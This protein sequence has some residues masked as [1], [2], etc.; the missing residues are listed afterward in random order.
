MRCRARAR[1][2]HDHGGGG[3]HPAEKAGC[4]ANSSSPRSS[5]QEARYGTPDPERVAELAATLERIAAARATYHLERYGRSPEEAEQRQEIVPPGHAHARHDVP[6]LGR[7]LRQHLGKETIEL[8]QRRPQTRSRRRRVRVTQQ[9]H[10][11]G[12]TRDDGPGT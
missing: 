4:I 3:A 7:Y 6:D 10:T 12:N 1:L 8:R 9:E 5:V 11:Q 2:Y